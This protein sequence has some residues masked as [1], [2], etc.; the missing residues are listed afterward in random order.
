LEIPIVHLTTELYKRIYQI[1]SKLPKKERL[2][3]FLKIES[4][5][6][7]ILGSGIEASLLSRQEKLPYL[8]KLRREIEL[9]KRLI[10]VCHEL[11]IIEQVKYIELST[12]LQELSMMTNGWIKSLN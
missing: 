5:V 11:Q 8:Y 7:E 10:R 12:I 2:G 3:I 4:G 1:S 9:V 6:L